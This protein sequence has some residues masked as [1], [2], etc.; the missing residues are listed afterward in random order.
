MR[1][2]NCNICFINH[3]RYN[4]TTYTLSLPLERSR[5]PVVFI[6]EARPVELGALNFT[7]VT[8]MTSRQRLQSSSSHHLDVPRIH[9]S[10]VG[11][12]AF[13]VFS[14]TVWND[15]PPHV[16]SAPSLVISRQRLKSFWFSQSCSV[17]HSY[18][19]HIAYYYLFI[20]VDLAIIDII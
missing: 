11:K 6:L 1:K 12:R 5:R 2:R 14:A 19:I 17:G 16:T 20:F 9:L 18:L 15:L 10:T 13:L 8:D 4:M 7:H 3:V